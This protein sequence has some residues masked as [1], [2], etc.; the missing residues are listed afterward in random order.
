MKTN[1]FKDPAFMSARERVDEL[2]AIFAAG[3]ARLRKTLVNNLPR[4]DA[5][6]SAQVQK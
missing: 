4:R 5:G 2:A 6:S 3:L 1:D